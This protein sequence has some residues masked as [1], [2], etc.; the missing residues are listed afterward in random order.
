MKKVAKRKVRSN[1]FSF[2]R[3]VSR[4]REFIVPK[5]YQ[6][7]MTPLDVGK[8][9][10]ITKKYDGDRYVKK[11]FAWEHLQVLMLFNFFGNR[12]LR[13]L[14]KAVANSWI[15][16]ILRIG[17]PG[18]LFVSDVIV[19]SHSEVICPHENSPAG[20]FRPLEFAGSVGA[21]PV[22]QERVILEVVGLAA[23]KIVAGPQQ[24]PKTEEESQE[25]DRRDTAENNLPGTAQ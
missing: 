5:K 13:N 12:T 4:F 18:T 21:V 20:V 19:P 10:E 7:L 9:A 8:F 2:G 23:W 6:E 25:Q 15:F 3:V 22:S 14:G 16:R 17:D 24:F 11:F 1:G